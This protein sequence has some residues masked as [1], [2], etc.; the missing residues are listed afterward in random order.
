MEIQTKP[1]ITYF[2][3]HESMSSETRRMIMDLIS[4]LMI[5]ENCNPR[6]V[7]NMLYGAFDGYDYG[8]RF[9]TDNLIQELQDGGNTGLVNQIFEV[10]DI[11]SK[12][13]RTTH[14]NNNN[15]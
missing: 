9:K 8:D 4:D 5:M 3:R 2:N 14:P 10:D 6:N 11:I 15:F 12:Y 1:Q 13:P 7:I